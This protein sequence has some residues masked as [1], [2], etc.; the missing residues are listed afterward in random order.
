MGFLGSVFERKEYNPKAVIARA[1]G[2]STSAMAGSYAVGGSWDVDKAIKNGYERVMLAFRCVD[3]IASAQADIPILV[4]RGDRLDGE[5]VEY[6]DV[7]RLLNGRPN[8]YEDSWQFR[9]RLSSLLLLSIRGCF[10][11]MVP[12]LSGGIAEFHILPPGMVE[13]I[14]GERKKDG[15]RNFVDGYRVLR[16]VDGE[17]EELPP[18]RVLWIK[19]KTHPTDPYR[20]MT[21]LVAAGLAVETDYLARMFNRNFLLNDGR[22]GMLV[23]IKGQLGNED[24]SEIKRR[25]SGGYMQAGRSSVVE[26]EGLDVIDLAANPRDIQWSEMIQGGKDDILLAFGTPESMLGNASGRTFDNADAEKGNWYETTVVNHCNAVSRPFD[27]VLT[28]SDQDEDYVVHD[29]NSVPVLQR[30]KQMREDRWAAAFAAGLCTLDDYLTNTGKEALGVPGSR[31]HF[32]PNSLV[33]GKDQNDVREAASLPQ[34]GGQFGALGGN[35]PAARQFSESARRGAL[36]GIGQGTR[37][38]NNVIASRALAM[39]AQKQAETSETKVL[40]GEVADPHEVARKS[41]EA[42]IQGAL[43]MWSD[44]QEDIVLDRLMQT[45]TRK[46]TRHWEGDPG[47]KALETGRIVEMDRWAADVRKSLEAHIRKVLRQEAMNA[48]EDLRRSGAIEVLRVQG[49]TQ[50]GRSSLG[51]LVGNQ[52]TFIDGLAEPIINVVESAARNMSERVAKKIET[53]DAEGASMGDIQRE[54]RSMMSSRSP[55]RKSLATHITTTAI[56]AAKAGVYGK[57]EQW[58]QKTW[59]AHHDERTRPSHFRADGQTRAGNKHFIVGGHKMFC[60]ND[61]TA[62]IGETANCRC[63]TSYSITLPPKIARRGGVL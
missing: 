2:G 16:S 21:P 62:P 47:T 18:E 8:T 6:R 27:R 22:P 51:E 57:A 5:E 4:R 54:V 44:R 29:F 58:I 38:L 63:W 12:S 14:P 48:A 36:A 55:W 34:V 10:V 23:A 41:S 32:L 7:K 31:V 46:G 39:A 52:K 20:Q 60:P 17:T 19:A 59:N 28:A 40:E 37:A 15:T 56:E 49:K 61:P 45:K 30:H 42:Y 24:A 35:N 53:L 33:V 50:E 26:A 3:A 43:G 25:F 9:Y 13:P 1:T 11:E